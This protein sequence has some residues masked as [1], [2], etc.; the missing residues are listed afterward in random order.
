[1]E[2]PIRATRKPATVPPSRT[3]CPE[4]SATGRPPAAEIPSSRRPGFSVLATAPAAARRSK[5]LGTS[6]ARRTTGRGGVW[7]SPGRMK[8]CHL[9][10]GSFSGLSPLAPPAAGAAA[11]VSGA[12][13]EEHTSEL[14]S[15]SDLVCRLL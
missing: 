2:R 3:A 6:P 4:T 11:G 10:G 14:Q 12:R 9:G 7:R 8:L 1:A 5:G 15:R 13:S